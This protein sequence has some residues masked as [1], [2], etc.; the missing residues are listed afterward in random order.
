VKPRE[1]FAMELFDFSASTSRNKKNLKKM[2]SE[3]IQKNDEKEEASPMRTL[4]CFGLFFLLRQ[5]RGEWFFLLKKPSHSIV[6]VRVKNWFMCR[7]TSFRK[8]L[9]GS[10]IKILSGIIEYL[11]IYSI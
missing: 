9:H 3:I 10:E 11:H 7:M 6:C 5:G 4:G 2:P 1:T 8:F